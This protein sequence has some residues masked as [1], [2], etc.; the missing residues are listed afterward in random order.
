MWVEMTNLKALHQSMLRIKTDMQ[1]FQVK[2]GSASF[3]CLF[4]TRDAPFVLTLTSRGASPKFFRF[5]VVGGYKIKPYFGE[6][7]SELAALLNSGANTGQKL[8]P[9]NFLEQLNSAIPSKANEK[10][11]PPPQEI[12]R[13]RPDITEQRDRPYFDTW[14]YWTQE[15]GRH[16]STENLEKT[17]LV[18][19]RDAWEYS[20]E[21]NASSKWSAKELG[22]NW[23]SEEANFKESEKEK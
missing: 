20:K 11:V 14:M 6:D 5:D 19:G 13:L 22:R 21:M 15:S 4:S 16:P 3:D 23:T 12:I 8:I 9:R 2:T 1:Q 7:Y 10:N 18:L 17:K